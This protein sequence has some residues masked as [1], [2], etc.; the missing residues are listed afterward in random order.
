MEF[1]L[2]D[3]RDYNDEGVITAICC[4]IPQVNRLSN[5]HGYSPL[6]WTLG[7]TPIASLSSSLI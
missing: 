1:F 4:S 3:S 2:H 5:V 7:Y 6:Q